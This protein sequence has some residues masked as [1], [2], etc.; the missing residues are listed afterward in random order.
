MLHSQSV[1]QSETPV[2]AFL[3]VTM[4]KLAKRPK[5]VHEFTDMST[6]SQNAGF[7]GF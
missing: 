3:L 2:R 7:H 5:K 4:S 6:Q 1:S